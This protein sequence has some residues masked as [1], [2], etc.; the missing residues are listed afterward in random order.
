MAIL[1]ECP[2]CHRKQA[3]KNKVCTC[4][5]DMDKAKK[6][7]RVRYWISYRY[8][9]PKTGKVRQRKES[10]AKFADLN[11]YSIEDA[12]KAEAKRTVQKAEGRILDML[13]ESNFT[14]SE[15]TKWYLNL[16][17]VKKLASYPRVRCCLGNFNEVFAN[18]VA[19]SIK[20]L[21]LENY[22]DRR[23]EEGAAPATI[24]LEIIIAGGMVRK[25]W[26]NDLV[27]DRPVK[28]F[29]KVK[30][31]LKVGA[32][33]RT[34]T[35]TIP[36]YIALVEMA[37]DHIKALIIVGYNTGM[38]KGE[39][40]SLKWSH[41]DHRNS[42]IRL[43]A[44]LT[45]EKKPKNIPINHHVKRVLDELPRHLHHDYIFT[46]KGEP[47]KREFRVGLKNACELAGIVYG[48]KAEGGFRFHDLRTT[49]K[50][51]MLR[52]GVDKVYRDAIVGHSLRG[53]DAFYLKLSDND[54]HSAMAK[55]TTW[56]D[57]EIDVAHPV[58]QV[59][60]MQP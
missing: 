56:L 59:T 30:N 13:P 45:K 51:N 10:V 20:P 5:Q 11:P 21:D 40:L 57:N 8:K 9:D 24:D 23:E 48:Q 4:G 34:R 22:Q 53:M 58:A 50:T 16:N 54:L 55:F 47:I 38:R 6:G 1:A 7:K 42:M 12:R 49:F 44:E 2:I 39:L 19:G 14:F 32:N 36:E 28:A 29:R 31:K 18:Q 15:L 37:S 41:I 35:L 27:S 60:L 43:P 52:A 17:S 3:V 26:D 46:F 25:A 33:A